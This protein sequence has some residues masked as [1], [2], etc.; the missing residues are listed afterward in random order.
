MLHEFLSTLTDELLDYTEAEDESDI[1]YE[2][3]IDVVSPKFQSWPFNNGFDLD[4]KI[5]TF[6]IRTN[7]AESIEIYPDDGLG[8]ETKTRYYAFLNYLNGGID[9]E[10]NTAI[11]SHK[12]SLNKILRDTCF[13]QGADGCVERCKSDIRGIYESLETKVRDI[14]ETYKDEKVR[15]LNSSKQ[16]DK[17][18][19]K[20]R[21]VNSGYGY[22]L[23]HKFSECLAQNMLTFLATN[24][25]TPNANMP[26]EIIEYNVNQKHDCKKDFTFKKSNNPS[27]ALHEAISQYVPGNTVVLENKTSIIRGVAYTGQYKQSESSPML[28]LFPQSLP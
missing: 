3:I 16:S 28:P 23:R 7:D 1:N 27:Y 15:L 18:K 13:E 8:D 19:V 2:K 6:T 25:F 9:E 17:N 11:E 24:R 10:G 14:A 12:E 5:R 20:G 21:A 26:V 22:L 4:E